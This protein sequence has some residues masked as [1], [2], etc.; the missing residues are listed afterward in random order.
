M[1]VS[2]GTTGLSAASTAVT[3][4]TS[5]APAT[6]VAAVGIIGMVVAM[7]TTMPGVGATG[8]LILAV[9]NHRQEPRD[10][11]VDHKG[12]T[13]PSPLHPAPWATKI[14]SS[15]GQAVDPRRALR[16]RRSTL[17]AP[18]AGGPNSK[19]H[20]GRETKPR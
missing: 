12:V 19:V 1:A 15:S 14:P 11:R 10:A 9:A 13:R 18:A 16:R 20:H 7:V 2:A 17:P 6:G 3:A 8:I 4:I 5:M